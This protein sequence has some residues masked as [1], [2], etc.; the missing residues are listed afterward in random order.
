MNR[1][2][3]E[4]TA[5]D[6]GGVAYLVNRNDW[7]VAQQAPEV[8]LVAS[9]GARGRDDAHCGG[10]MIHHTNGG[11]IGDHASDGFRGGVTRDSDHV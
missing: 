2:G 9:L 10:L 1:R 7:G 8:D 5:V 6:E 4:T 11:F 3:D